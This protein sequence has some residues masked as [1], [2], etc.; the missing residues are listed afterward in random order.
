MLSVTPVGQER[1]FIPVNP[2]Q[3]R[4]LHSIKQIPKPRRTEP[5]APIHPISNHENRDPTERFYLLSVETR[6]SLL[7]LDPEPPLHAPHPTD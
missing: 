7:D 5:L 4:R 3:R 2:I 1:L 6:K